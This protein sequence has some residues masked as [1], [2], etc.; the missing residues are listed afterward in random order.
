MLNS[1]L[2]IDTQ[3]LLEYETAA[4]SLRL[5]C[6]LGRVWFRHHVQRPLAQDQKTERYQVLTCSEGR[7]ISLMYRRPY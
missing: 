7:H 3:L 6:Q 5:F 2:R 1:V 4:L